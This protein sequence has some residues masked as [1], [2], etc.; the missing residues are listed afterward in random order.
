MENGGKQRAR[1]FA[2]NLIIS[3]VE[4]SPEEFERSK[5]ASE[6]EA[7][8]EHIAGHTNQ[9]MFRVAVRAAV[10][11]PVALQNGRDFP[12]RIFS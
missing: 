11:S 4:E 12:S 6:T 2:R 8:D 10:G 1:I 3:L 5:A 9:R 7:I